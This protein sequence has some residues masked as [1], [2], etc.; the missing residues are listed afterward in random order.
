MLVLLFEEGVTV[1]K[2]TTAASTALVETADSRSPQI[3]RENRSMA[4]VSSRRT[5]LSVSGSMAKT[6]S[7][8]VS[9]TRYSPGCVAR[10]R[11]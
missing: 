5:H 7:G 4:I 1:S 3:T 2:S 11:P 6:S 9:R 8:V 10:R